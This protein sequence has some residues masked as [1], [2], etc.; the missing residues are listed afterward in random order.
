M[1]CSI[2]IREPFSNNLII[3]DVHGRVFWKAHD[4]NVAVIYDKKNMNEG[5]H[6]CL[7]GSTFAF[8]GK[9]DRR[10]CDQRCRVLVLVSE[11]DSAYLFL[12]LNN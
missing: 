1:R 12:L 3:A 5:M 7:I 9:R 6:R 8:V 10:Q 11:T 2:C 4:R